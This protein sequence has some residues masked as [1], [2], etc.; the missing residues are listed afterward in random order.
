M[1]RCL[2]TYQSGNRRSSRSSSAR[3]YSGSTPLRLASWI[4]I[5]AALASAYSADAVG[6][7]ERLQVGAIAQVGQQQKALR[8]ILIQDRWDMHAG[9]GEQTR[10][11]DEGAAVLALGWGVHH[12]E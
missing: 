5:N 2:A 11:G 8:Q 1:P 4:L 7:V 6:G 10:D 12:D 9:I 3:S